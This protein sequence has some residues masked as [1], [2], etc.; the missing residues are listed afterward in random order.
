MNDH[1]RNLL[2][3]LATLPNVRIAIVSARGSIRLKQDVD[4]PEIILAGNYGMEMRHL[5][6]GKEWIA[7]QALQAIPELRRLHDELQ[8]IAKQFQGAILEDDYYSFCLHWHL[9]P[10]N[11]RA[12]LGQAL[13]QLN[14][15]LD[16]VYMRN[17]P[18][19]Y[20]FMPKME[21]NKG[22]ALE[23]L[24]SLPQLRSE[25]PYF[26]YIGD[27]DQDE[28][29]FEW[30][31]NSGGSSVRVGALRGKT[32]ATYR[33]DQPAD[34]IWFLEQL[35]E[36]RS[37]LAATA[38]N[39]EEDPAERERRIER[40]FATMKDNYAKGLTERIKELK[41][42]VE[43]AKN[44]PDDLNSLTEARTRTHRMKGTIG[45]YGFSEISSQLGVI[46]VALE[47]VEK[48]SS[49]NKNL[50][51]SWQDAIPLIENSFTKALTAATTPSQMA[52]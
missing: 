13:Q 39:P 42:L 43:K 1:T 10:E 7:P 18:T 40:V 50:A 15:S 29:G 49:L 12:T 17:L 33:L 47:S 14:P 44:Q 21:W 25:T 11:K 41:A 51:E 19:S 35:L 20:E 36:Q 28:P 3:K 45:S 46:E 5:P 34:L 16:T 24:A 37:L 32:K 8:L 6:D 2:I 23:Q 38:F 27:T 22:L 4:A 31:N 26:V 9:V 52:Q 30:A 48:S